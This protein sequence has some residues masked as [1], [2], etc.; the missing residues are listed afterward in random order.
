VHVAVWKKGGTTEKDPTMTILNTSNYSVTP[1]S[2]RRSIR[3]FIIQLARLLNGWVATAIAQRVRHA[4]LTVLRSL[5]DRDL[6][7]IGVYRCVTFDF[8]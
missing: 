3:F 1:I 7:D 4:Q 5:R 2:F 8:D 6:K